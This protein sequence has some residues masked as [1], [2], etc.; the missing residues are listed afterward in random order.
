M[1][2][3]AQMKTTIPTP[4]QLRKQHLEEALQNKVGSKGIE[5]VPLSKRTGI[6]YNARLQ[7]LVNQIRKRINENIVPLIRRLESQYTADSWDDD[8]NS[9]FDDEFNFWSSENVHDVFEQMALDFAEDANETNRRGFLRSTERIGI[10]LY[11]DSQKIRDYLKA[12]A[13]DNVSLIKSIPEQY[14]GQVRSSVMTNMRAG[15]RPGVIV[16]S[17]R[18]QYGI[19]QN[20]ARLIARDQTAKINSGLNQRRQRESGFEYFQWLFE[21]S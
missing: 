10:N 12:T 13:T 19:T 9:A 2:I 1:T 5:A 15:N 8:I 17:L 16:N 18:D 11:G 6:M 4:Q 14:L 20:R 3:S 7:R 21:I